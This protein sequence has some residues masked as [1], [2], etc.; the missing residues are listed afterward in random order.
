MVSDMNNP[1]IISN[2][3]PFQVVNNGEP[4]EDGYN[5]AKFD[6]SLSLVLKD[7]DRIKRVERR[8]QKRFQ[9]KEDAFALIRP[10]SAE[11]LQIRG[12]SMG[13]IA[14]AVFNAK[15]AR[16]GRIDNISMGGLMFQHVAGKKQLNNNFVLDILLAGCRFYLASM[17]FKIIADVVLPEDI[18]GGSFEMRQV[19]C[20]FQSLSVKQEAK[21]KEFIF[22]HG[23]EIAKIS[24]NFS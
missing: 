20:Q 15:P 10:I 8:G 14:C 12:R 1:Y 3:N 23:G 7:V 13:C 22:N 6:D 19:R 17:P 4:I 11:P 9:L 16:L 18:P 5:L 2:D 24:F 21:L